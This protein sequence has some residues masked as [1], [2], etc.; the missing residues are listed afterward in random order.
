MTKMTTLPGRHMPPTAAGR[1]EDEGPTEETQPVVP[2]PAPRHLRPMPTG[3]PVFPNARG[4]FC[5]GAAS[6]SRR[7]PLARGRRRDDE[8][9]SPD[10]GPR[11]PEPHKPVCADQLFR[12]RHINRDQEEAR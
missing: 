9:Q 11:P 5:L 7:R 4:R 1:F 6:L 3:L 8:A 2:G 10:H 12:G